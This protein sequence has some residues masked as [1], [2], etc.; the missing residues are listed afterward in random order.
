ML[1]EDLL[2]NKSQCADEELVIQRDPKMFEL[3]RSSP[4]AFLSKETEFLHHRS[5]LKN[6]KVQ[7]TQLEEQ[8]TA[9]HRLKQKNI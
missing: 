6:L 5:E 9:Y 2:T 3:K 8:V 4:A 1:Q 7:I